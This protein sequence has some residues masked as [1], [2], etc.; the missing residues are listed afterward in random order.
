MLTREHPFPD[1]LQ[2]NKLYK[3]IAGGEPPVVTPVIAM[4]GFQHSLLAPTFAEVFVEGRD[5][6][7]SLAYYISFFN[8]LDYVWH[9]NNIFFLTD[10]GVVS[11]D[12]HNLATIPDWININRS[13]LPADY[14]SYHSTPLLPFLKQYMMYEDADKIIELYGKHYLPIYFTI[15]RLWKQ[16]AYIKEKE[17][18][19]EM[20]GL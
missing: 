18:A 17:K 9:Y 4:I 13:S 6:V 1:N 8:R 7:S 10:N 14:D 19:N 16:Q 5:S 20:P 12:L 11:F 2:L 15:Q 3:N